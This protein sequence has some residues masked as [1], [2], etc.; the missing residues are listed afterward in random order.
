MGI[1]T[2]GNSENIINATIVARAMGIKIIGLTGEK[3]GKL[4]DVS[5]VVI[6]VPEIETYM[7]QELHLPIYHCWCLMLEEKFFG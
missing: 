7:I 6:K 4:A 5:D 2:S 3:G 1:S